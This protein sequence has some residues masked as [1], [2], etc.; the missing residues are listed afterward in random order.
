MPSAHH[1]VTIRYRL[2]HETPRPARCPESPLDSPRGLSNVTT[3]QGPV[4]TRKERCR[5]TNSLQIPRQPVASPGLTGGGFG[6]FLLL[7]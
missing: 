5:I 1:P 3:P 4:E 6:G 2:T 7:P